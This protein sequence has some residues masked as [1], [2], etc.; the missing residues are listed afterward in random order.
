MELKINVTMNQDDNMSDDL[1]KSAF[2]SQ[3]NNGWHVSNMK[4]I[5]EYSFGIE[6]G[7]ILKQD[8]FIFTVTSSTENPKFPPFGSIWKE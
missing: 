6:N 8:L 3:L 7:K 4:K 2:I 5:K 1:V